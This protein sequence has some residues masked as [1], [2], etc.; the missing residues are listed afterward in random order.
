MAGYGNTSKTRVCTGE[1]VWERTDTS[2]SFPVLVA[3]HYD[4]DYQVNAIS[5][6][7]IVR[8]YDGFVGSTLPEVY[9]KILFDEKERWSNPQWHPQIIWIDLGSNDFAT[10][11]HPTEK[12]KS[13]DELQQDFQA[14][15]L[16]F[17]KQ[18][19]SRQPDAFFILSASG[20]ECEAEVK[21]VVEKWKAMG[22]KRVGYVRFPELTLEGC[23]W[24]LTVEDDEKV[25]GTLVT[26]IDREIGNAW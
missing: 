5:G 7:G 19:R 18:L 9:S 20:K 26:Y 14:T 17:V 4:A 25:M 1:Q 12:W 10:P 8:N 6:R 11:L 21:S 23:D 3:K 13:Q 22:E 16:A 24:H 15:Y 2:S